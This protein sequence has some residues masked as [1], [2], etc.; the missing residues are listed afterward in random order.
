MPPTP[1]TE[2]AAAKHSHFTREALTRE[3]CPQCGIMLPV[4][5]TVPTW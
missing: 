4:M 3:V 2:P 1:T 5:R